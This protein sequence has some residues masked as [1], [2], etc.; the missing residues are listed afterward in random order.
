MV[1]MVRR[2]VGPGPRSDMT[3]VHDGPDGPDGP[4]LVPIGPNAVRGPCWSPR[5]SAGE[6]VNPLA[7]SQR[8]A[9][10]GT[11]MTRSL[12]ISERASI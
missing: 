3:M 9:A 11:T 7:L 8:K 4:Y 2:D 5:S 1:P 10:I 12:F 6:D